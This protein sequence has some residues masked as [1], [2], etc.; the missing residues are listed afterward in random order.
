MDAPLAFLRDAVGGFGR[1]RDARRETR[2][3][4]REMR[5]ERYRDDFVLFCVM[6]R[7]L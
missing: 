6:L 4:T 2:E 3:E 7:T 1:V 5:G